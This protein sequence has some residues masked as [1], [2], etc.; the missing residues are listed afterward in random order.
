MGD[1]FGGV[2]ATQVM[3]TIVASAV[4]QYSS[5]AI[6]MPWEVGKTLLQVQWVPRDAK[7]IGELELEDEEIE[8]ALPEEK[9]EGEGDFEDTYSEGS[10]ENEAYFADPSM[11]SQKKLGPPRVVD[12]N[13]YLV[14]KSV[15]EEGTRPEFII[16]VG[17][18]DGV[19]QMIKQVTGFPTEGWLALWKGL[20]TSCLSEIISSTMQPFIHQFIQSIFLPNLSPFHQPPIFL[21]IIS[22]LLTGFV[23][24][25]LDL[26][27]TRLIVQSHSLRYRTYTGP[28]DALSQI[29]RDEGGLKGIYFHPHLFIPTVL[30]NTIRPLVSLTL[31]G[32][33]AAQIGSNISENTHPI[34]W[35]LAEFAGSC[36][37]LLVTLPLETARRRLQIQARGS[38]KPLRA[39]VEVRPLL[40]EEGKG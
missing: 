34:S 8:G 18:A 32:I 22:H 29:L 17:I 40:G 6:A 37:G 39:C 9:G 23:L 25:P 1:R 35:S 3:K 16:P 24:S 19:W 33:L 12:E 2:N 38:A 15:L 26:I 5:S 27:R 4:L 7:D 11:V 14:R 21:P 28:I 20:L 10:A 13:G 30:E 31:P 36:L